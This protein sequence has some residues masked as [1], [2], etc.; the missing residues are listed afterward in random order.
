MSKFGNRKIE[1]EDG[2]FDSAKE[3]KRWCE[4]KLMDRSNIIHDLRRQVAFILIPSQRDQESGKVIEREVRYIADFVY[5]F[6]GKTVVEDVKS[7]ATKTP[8]Y[9]I[10]RKL[11]L[12]KFGIRVSEV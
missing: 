10:K 3:Y 4:L 6:D 11:M 1:T 12:Q 7:E 8:E 5:T 9:I 2:K